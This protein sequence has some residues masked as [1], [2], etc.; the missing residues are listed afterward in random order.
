MPQEMILL[1]RTAAF[2][3]FFHTL[4]SPDHYLLIV[5]GRPEM[6]DAENLLDYPAVRRGSCKLRRAGVDKHRA[7]DL[8]PVAA[9]ESFHGSLAAWALIA[10]GLVYFVWGMRRAWKHRPR[11]YPR[12]LRRPRACPPACCIRKKRHLHE[13]SGA[14]I[15]RPECFYHFRAR[16][17]GADSAPDVSGG[18]GKSGG[19]FWSRPYSAP[20]PFDH[21]GRCP[22][23]SVGTQPPSAAGWSGNHALAGG[24]ICLC[25]AA[26]Q[27]LGL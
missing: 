22:C 12:P 3:G 13:E 1:L 16:A 15:S 17:A 5:M 26:I 23:L 27:F 9:I 18:E 10:F 11:T 24:S 2:L 21:A 25:G 6:V 4:H 19:C 14:A 7:G 20:R 8:L